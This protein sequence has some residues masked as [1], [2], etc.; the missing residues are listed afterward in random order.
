[1]RKTAPPRPYHGT[2]PSPPLHARRIAAALG[3]AIVTLVAA[4]GE[5]RVPVSPDGRALQRQLRR[6]WERAASETPPPLPVRYEVVVILRDGRVT[7]VDIEGPDVGDLKPCW[8][9]ALRR[10]PWPATDARVA[11][12]LVFTRR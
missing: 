7:A 4:G 3:F 11:F 1:M 8:R 6:C 2:V 10:H 5:A 12:P 9:R